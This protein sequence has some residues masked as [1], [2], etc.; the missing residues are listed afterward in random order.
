MAAAA[1][2]AEPSSSSTTAAQRKQNE[3]VQELPIPPV[4]A[5]AIAA[6]E[7]YGWET[8]HG[9]EA[10]WTALHW[11]ASEG[12]AQ[13]CERPL[14]CRADPSQPDNLGRSA[15]DYAHEADD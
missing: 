1:A 8:V 13:I 6:V 11:A 14:Q 7:R 4:Y 15:L 12:R 3:E 5:S 9:N 10:E 2:T